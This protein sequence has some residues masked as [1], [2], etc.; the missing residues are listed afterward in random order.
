MTK[1]STLRGKKTVKPSSIFVTRVNNFQLLLQILESSSI[2]NNRIFL[3]E[4]LQIIE[5]IAIDNY[6]IKIINK[7][8]IKI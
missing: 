8:Q 3:L 2:Y 7:E 4:R 6:E 1:I 5:E